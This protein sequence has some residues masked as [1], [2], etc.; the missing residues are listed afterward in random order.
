MVEVN[1]CL[2]QSWHLEIQQTQGIAFASEN[3]QYN[4]LYR[5]RCITHHSVFEYT[6]DNVGNSSPRALPTSDWC[7]KEFCY[8]F[9]QKQVQLSEGPGSGGC[10]CLS[11]TGTWDMAPLSPRLGYWYWSDRVC[12]SYWANSRYLQSFLPGN[13]RYQE[14]CWNSILTALFRKSNVLPL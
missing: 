11:V 4:G 2:T 10:A 9:Q 13:L 12:C 3:R 8:Q 6:C 5:Q 14:Y 7:S 1:T